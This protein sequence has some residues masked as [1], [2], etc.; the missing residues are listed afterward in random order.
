MGRV[1][2]IKH[3][4][5]SAARGAITPPRLDIVDVARGVALAMMLVYHLVWD[6]EFF[7]LI[8]KG[9]AASPPMRGFSHAIASAFLIIAGVSVALAHRGR[10][11]RDAFRRQFT[12]VA[13]AAAAVTLVTAYVMP[14]APIT[15]GILHAMALGVLL[16]ALFAKAPWGLTMTVAMAMIVAP[17]LLRSPTFD[18]PALQ[19]IGLGTDEPSALDWRPMLPWTGVML[20]GLA[21]ARTPRGQAFL[22]RADEFKADDDAISRG[23][24]WLGKRTLPIYLLHQP[25]LFA[26]LYVIALMGGVAPKFGEDRGFV[27]ACRAECVAKGAKAE[28]CAQACGCVVETVKRS[29]RWD[30]VIKNEPGG[31]EAAAEAAKL[32]LPK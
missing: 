26:V 14:Q 21:L 20:F 17:S 30:A 9:Y 4:S 23:L 22:V 10:F 7:G 19:W 24:R 32:C 13:L 29:G 18:A 1:I 28:V 12:K 15:F 5:A 2:E 11:K 31:D 16:T 27:E 3:P 25:A 6:F 8:G